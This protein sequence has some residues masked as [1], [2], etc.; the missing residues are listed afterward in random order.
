MPTRAVDWFEKFD[1]L[2]SR[3]MK[4][5]RDFAEIGDNTRQRFYDFVE[6]EFNRWGRNGA[7]CILRTICETAEAPIKHN[8]LIGELMHVFF[9]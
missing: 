4:E 2:T 1:G 5:S 7:E 8:G 3:K 9:T 6:K